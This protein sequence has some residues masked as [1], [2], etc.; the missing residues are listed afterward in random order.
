MAELSGE[1]PRE[2]TWET[3]RGT[4]GV[5]IG[6]FDY[7]LDDGF[8]TLV[9]VWRDQSTEDG[10][11]VGTIFARHVY[12]MRANVLPIPFYAA[13]LAMATKEAEKRAADF[14][15][16]EGVEL[17]AI[18]EP[19][20]HPFTKSQREAVEAVVAAFSSPDK[21]QGEIWDIGTRTWKKL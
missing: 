6:D 3:W 20:S 1:L 14:A 18:N 2:E 7:G 15:S 9:Q 19:R 17:L 5:T 10:I 8:G 13:R 12:R 4:V 16:Q 21:H 11:N